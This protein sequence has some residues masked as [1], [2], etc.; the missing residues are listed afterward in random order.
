MKWF[1]LYIMTAAAIAALVSVQAVAQNEQELLAPTGR[2]RVGVYLGHAHCIE[3]CPSSGAKR[4]T[5][6]RTEFFS[7]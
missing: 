3:Q 6:A 5:Y 1:R 4:K 7:V 2:L